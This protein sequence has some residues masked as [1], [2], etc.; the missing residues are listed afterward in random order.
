M[1]PIGRFRLHSRC[2]VFSFKSGGGGGGG[3]GGKGKP[4]RGRFFS[5][6]LC[7][8]R[9]RMC[10]PWVF[11]IVP[12][13][14]PICFAQSPPFLTYIGGPKGEALHLS[15]ES[16]IFV[17]LH[18]FNFFL[19]GLIKFNKKKL[20]LWGV[21]VRPKIVINYFGNKNFMQPMGKAQAYT[22]CALHFIFLSLGGGGFRGGYFSGFHGS[23]MLTIPHHPLTLTR[24]LK[25]KGGGLESIMNYR[26]KPPTPI[27]L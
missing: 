27:S 12:C 20:D 9:F 24:S 21:K 5:F 17:N 1:Q 14:N 18:S 10:S 26:I 13:F 19:S 2:L 7:S 16:S 25:G 3:R 6:F 11:P 8:N 15:I 4:Q 22:K 23:I